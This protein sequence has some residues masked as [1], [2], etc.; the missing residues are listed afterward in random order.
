MVAKNVMAANFSPGTVMSE[1]IPNIL[2]AC[3]RA[4]VKHLVMQSGIN[5]SDGK[6]L[7]AVNRWAVDLMRRIYFNPSQFKVKLEL[8]RELG[9]ISYEI[10]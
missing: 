2:A 5:L 6:E 10:K 4:G 1:G 7:S 8:I 3:Q 9:G